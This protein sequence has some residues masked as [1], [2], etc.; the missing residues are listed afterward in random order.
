MDE[1]LLGRRDRLHG[2]IQNVVQRLA[3]RQQHMMRRAPGEIE[4][5]HSEHDP[6][7]DRKAGI[8]SDREKS[9]ERHAGNPAVVGFPLDR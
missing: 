4:N 1:L 9:L 3:D 5:G 8:G 7:Q 6:Q 2:E